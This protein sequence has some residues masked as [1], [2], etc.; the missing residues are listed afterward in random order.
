MD[1]PF[2]AFGTGNDKTFNWDWVA[3]HNYSQGTYTITVKICHVNC[4]GAEGSGDSVDT[5]IVVIPPANIPPVISGVPSAET[6]NEEAPYTFTATASDVD[7][8]DT[9]NF[10]LSGEP[11]GATI[12]SS[13]GVFSWT[14]TEVQGPGVYPFNVRVSDGVNNTDASIT[15]TVTEVNTAPIASGASV[16]TAMNTLQAVTLSANDVDSPTNTLTYSI[17]GN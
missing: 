6:I 10:S 14:P 17:V 11:S 4:T 7:T 5:T 3:S 1:V 16:S 9:L 2:S 12:D 13:S 8:G 15:I